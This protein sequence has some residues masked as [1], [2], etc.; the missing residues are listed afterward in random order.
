MLI[1]RGLQYTM[2]LLSL[3]NLDLLQETLLHLGFKHLSPLDL[4]S[5]S[6]YLEVLLAFILSSI[7]YLQAMHVE[8]HLI[9]FILSL[10]CDIHN[11]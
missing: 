8:F 1:C 3:V 2:S 7:N 10:S 4:L 6:W 9:M 5:C 11:P